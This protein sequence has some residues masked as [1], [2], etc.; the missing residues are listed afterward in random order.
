MD[1]RAFRKLLRHRGAMIG[2]AL[3]LFVLALGL[4]GPWL[5]PH[6]PAQQFRGDLLIDGLPVGP[7][8]VEGFPLGA[9]PL[10]RDLLSRLLHGARLSL[11]IALL[12]TLIATVIGVSVG[13]ISGY[14]GGLIDGVAMRFVDLILSLPFLLIAIVIQKSLDGAGILFI[15]V[16]LGVLS[17]TG[18]A[19][20]TRAKTL[21]ARNLEYVEAARALG[22]GEL[23]IL[24]RHV[25]PNIVGPALAIGTLM[26]ANMILA[27]SA[28]SFL[29]FGLAPPAASWGSM[30]S[31]SQSL[32]E[33]Q[34]TL[35][36][37][38]ALLISATVF[39]FNLLGEG[40]RD[41]FDAKL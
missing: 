34:P 22:Y 40:L 9:D 35:T 32:M 7:F 21:Q 2:A 13:L 30:L 26:V 39:G 4:F 29:G 37:F 31:E 17:W 23:R 5:A 18:L 33:W 19:R 16:L 36:I 28:L 12:A 10:G 8:E 24:F 20:I 14:A 11:S 41:A 25:L 3:V 15:S 27:E 38:P 6:P 1:P